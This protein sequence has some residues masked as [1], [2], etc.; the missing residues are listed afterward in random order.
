LLLLLAAAAE[1]AAR[2]DWVR[3]RFPFP[4]V[5]SP[6][7]DLDERLAALDRLAATQGSVE[8]IVLGSSMVR[9]GY[10]AAEFSR[11]YQASAGRPLHCENFGVGGMV[12]AQAGDIAR[13]LV[14]LYHPQWLVFG[15]SARDYS[16]VVADANISGA[17]DM[18]NTPWVR[19]RLGRGFTFEG[20]LIDH[21][22]AYHYSFGVRGWLQRPAASAAA[23]RPPED[24]ASPPDA[25]QEQ[26]L[27]RVLAHYSV[28][29]EGL[30]GL[31]TLLAL[32]D[33]G[34]H[35]IVAEVPVHSTY[36]QFF[37]RG[38]QDMRLFRDVI[39]QAAR[40]QG[41]VFLTPDGL[42]DIPDSEWQDRNHLNA[43]GRLTYSAWLASAMATETARVQAGSQSP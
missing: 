9:A 25:V 12:A 11:A 22:Y 23:A 43:Q 4:G 16:N 35:I 29:A 40:Q 24:L 32:R 1:A 13:L 28:S 27:Y 17:N 18:L 10:E 20:W 7:P 30:A 31:N 33:R 5:N 26:G 39:G 6:N 2:T 41:A 38:A 21:S 15:T 3:S 34:V 8:C 14:D 36:V 42:L 37:G 19:Y